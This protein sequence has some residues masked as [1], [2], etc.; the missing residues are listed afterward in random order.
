[1]LSGECVEEAEVQAEKSVVTSGKAAG[2][3]ARILAPWHNSS[4]RIVM[5]DSGFGRIATV[6]LLRT[7]GLF[8]VMVIKLGK[9][10]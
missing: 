8:A 5:A 2:C 6:H 10:A 4:P 9:K 7:L 3:A 1:M